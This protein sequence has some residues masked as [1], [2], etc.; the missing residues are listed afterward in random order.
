MSDDRYLWDK[1]GP[2]ADDLVKW[3]SAL[4][5]FRHHPQA[6]LGAAPSRIRHH[7]R[8]VLLG[9]IAACIALVVIFVAH[10][11]SDRFT[12]TAAS[13]AVLVDGKH[14]QG[15]ATIT[16]GSTVETTTGA[17]A[18]IVAGAI[19]R[20]RIGPETRVTIVTVNPKRQLVLLERGSLHAQIV[21]EPYAFAIQVPGAVAH[22]MGCAYTIHTDAKGNGELIVT[23][24]WVHLRAAHRDS[25]VA[26]G[27]RAEL[28]GQNGPGI[29][30]ALDAGSQFQS[31][32]QTLLT[33]PATATESAAVHVDTLLKTARRRDALTLLNLLWRLPAAL[34]PRVF[35]R[36]VEF[37]PPPPAVS[38]DRVL[39]EDWS[40]VSEWWQAFGYP[41]SVKLPLRYYEDGR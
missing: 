34:R 19:G 22:D 27:F 11:R 35:Q 31:T 6:T 13:G 15:Q 29:P 1:S 16:A 37:A 25:L 23:S 17:S 33:E 3:E 38:L 39:A 36:L 7:R 21:A 14:I 18:E 10:R 12:V 5:R 26:E 32:V 8:T 24:G 30:I 28:G 40:L 20:L 9:A 4:A 41:K 2:V